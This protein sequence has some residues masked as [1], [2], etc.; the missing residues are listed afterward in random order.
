MKKWTQIAASLLLALSAVPSFAVP[1]EIDRA[2]TVVNED[3]ILKS[4]IDLMRKLVL[5]RADGNTDKLPSAE[6]LNEQI[7]NE[8]INQKLQFGYSFYEIIQIIGNLEIS[9]GKRQGQGHRV[10]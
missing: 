8:L 9:L 10:S 3:V 1:N 2:V 5:F 6:I 4:D 7:L